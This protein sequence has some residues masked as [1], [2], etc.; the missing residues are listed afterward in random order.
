[1]S[2]FA[3][4]GLSVSSLVFSAGQFPGS[5]A[6]YLTAISLTSPATPAEIK[7]RSTITAGKEGLITALGGILFQT[8]YLGPLLAAFDN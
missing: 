2:F 6:A 1:V 3:L 4:L 8:P 5:D 7:G